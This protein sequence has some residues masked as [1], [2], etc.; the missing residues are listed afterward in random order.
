MGDD[1]AKLMENEPLGVIGSSSSVDIG[2]DRDN[3]A[4]KL[5]RSIVRRENP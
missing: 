2:A 5:G 4:K 1:R 3:R